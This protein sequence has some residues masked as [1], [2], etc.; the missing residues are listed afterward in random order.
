VPP[1][2]T[3]TDP[4]S[5]ANNNSPLVQGTAEAGS[6]VRVYKAPTTADCT[7]ATLA[8]IGTAASFASP[9]LQVSVPDNSSTRFRARAT[10]RAGNSSGCSSSS[11]VYVEDSSL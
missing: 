10:D 5:P 3:G 2:F 1:Q 7:A 9:G 6:T 8:V 4:T 11:I